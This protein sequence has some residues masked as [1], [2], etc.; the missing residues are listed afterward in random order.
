MKRERSCGAVVFRERDGV[1]EALL[2]RTP[3]G[4][5]TIP[6][7]HVERG[8]TDEQAAKREIME[9]T[10]FTVDIDSDFRY[11]VRYIVKKT[12]PK[13]VVFFAATFPEQ[14]EPFVCDDLCEVVWTPLADA[15]NVASRHREKRALVA[16]REYIIENYFGES[17]GI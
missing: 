1:A 10:G 3:K 11:T 5:L 13:D 15:E 2:I 9:E 16:A 4:Q 8:E 7:G 17:R 6:K 14:G 12:V